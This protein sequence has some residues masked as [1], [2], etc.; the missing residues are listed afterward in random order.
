MAD[1]AL[2]IRPFKAGDAEQL[3]NI[4]AR[5]FA[6]VFQSF[7]DIVGPEIGSVAFATA[8]GEQAR[9]LSDLCKA[10][11]AQKK[12]FVAE[13]AGRI[14]GFVAI[15]LDETQK[16][17]EVGLNAVDPDYAGQGFGTQLYEFAL[18]EMRAAGMK[19]AV[20]GTGGDPSHAPARRAYEKAG[21]GPFVPSQ[22]Y[23]R[24]L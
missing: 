9:H 4:R 11:A 2:S 16:L 10:D 14:V 8:E 12:L 17:G 5:A 3:Q 22:W 7:R 13:R 18:D 21:F 1:D 20:V 19:V 24:V 15:S 23:Y 6:P